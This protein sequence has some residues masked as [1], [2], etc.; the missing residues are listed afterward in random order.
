VR[1][2]LSY[3]PRLG[4]CRESFTLSGIRFDTSEAQLSFALNVHR[5]LSPAWSAHV[6]PEFGVSYFRQAVASSTTNY[7]PRNIYG[8]SLAVQAGL[9]IALG[10]GLALGARAVAQTYF[11]QL[12]NP[13]TPSPAVSALFTWGATVGVTWYLR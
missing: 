8:G 9:E 3:V 11:L 5:D 10:G 7:R 2:S 1:R 12:Q 4:L 13:S 6:G